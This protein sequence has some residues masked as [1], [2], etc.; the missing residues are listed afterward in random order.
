[1]GESN[2]RWMLKAGP[3]WGLPFLIPISAAIGGALGWWIDS[4]LGTKPWLAVVFGAAGVA[5]GI[6]ESV[7]ILI[8]ATRDDS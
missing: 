5:A 1:M 4:K 2:N 7:R 3:V 8:R 6:M